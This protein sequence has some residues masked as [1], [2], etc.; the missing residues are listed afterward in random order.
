ML[1][2]RLIK[3]EIWN[4]A[5]FQCIKK[6]GIMAFQNNE[7]KYMFNIAMGDFW[8]IHKLV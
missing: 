4:K 6:N 5:L 8:F 3:D 7:T 1:G 2:P